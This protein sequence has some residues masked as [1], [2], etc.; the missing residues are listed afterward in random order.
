MAAP[1]APADGAACKERRLVFE[2]SRAA[3]EHEPTEPLYAAAPDGAALSSMTQRQRL[4]IGT[5]LPYVPNGVL[6]SLVGAVTR[7]VE[8]LA[9]SAPR[10]GVQQPTTATASAPTTADDADED[11]D[12]EDDETALLEQ[13]AVELGGQFFAKAAG[14]LAP[15]AA[16]L[17]LPPPPPDPSGVSRAQLSGA[18]MALLHSLVAISGHR[19]RTLCESLLETEL[20]QPTLRAAE[21]W[22]DQRMRDSLMSS[23]AT[24]L[25]ARAAFPSDTALGGWAMD[26]LESYCDFRVRAKK[27][28]RGGEGWEGRR[29]GGKGGHVRATPR[30][31][32]AGSGQRAHARARPPTPV[33]PVG[34]GRLFCGGRSLRRAQATL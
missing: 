13:A 19:R 8:P 33:R 2:L 1:D 26:E 17:Q 22:P 18:L 16:P 3:L 31:A 11:E 27:E 28:G 15:E 20:W 5:T 34:G 9:R 12:E 7:A 10:R 25:C 14:L 24:A 29:R 30:H 21:W 32:Q 6:H 4:L 23:L